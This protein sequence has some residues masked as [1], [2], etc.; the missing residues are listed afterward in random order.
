VRPPHAWKII[1]FAHPSFLFGLS[2]IPSNVEC[3]PSTWPMMQT[4]RS[5][6]LFPPPPSSCL[7]LAKYEYDTLFVVSYLYSHIFIFKW[8]LFVW[9][10]IYSK[11]ILPYHIFGQHPSLSRPAL[12]Y[13][14][15]RELAQKPH[16]AFGCA[17]SPHAAFYFYFA[18]VVRGCY[19]TL[20][21]MLRSPK[22]HS[23]A[24]GFYASALLKKKW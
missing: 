21:M 3:G 12:I 7:V 8:N 4:R 23:A 2:Q 15:I 14:N 18:L 1:W 11:Y 13:F 10:R 16:A 22:K 6:V 19:L 24:C 20:L 17:N 5:S 9:I